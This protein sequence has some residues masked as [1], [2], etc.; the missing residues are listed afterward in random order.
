MRRIH[1]AKRLALGV[2]LAGIWSP[3]VWAQADQPEAEEA[4]VGNDIIVSARRKDESVQDVPMTV[5]VVTDQ[6]LKDLNLFNGSDL[7]NVAPGLTFAPTIPGNT[8]TL[9]LRGAAKGDAAGRQDPTVQTY[10]NEAPVTE[11]LIAEAL[12]DIGQVEVLRGPQGTLRGRPSA[13]GAITV[14]TKRPNLTKV[15][16][17]VSASVSTL[18]QFRGEAALNVPLVQDVLAVRVAGVVDRNENDGVRS[19]FFPDKP[20]Q[21][22]HSWRVSAR[23][24]PSDV[25]DVN[26]MY[27]DFKSTRATLNQVAGNG[28]AG[29]LRPAQGIT[30]GYNGPVISPFDRL[31]LS[32]NPAIRYLNHK[33][34]IGSIVLDLESHKISYVG[35]YNT[36]NNQ[37]YGGGNGVHLLPIPQPQPNPRSLNGKSKL[38]TQELRIESVGNSFWDYGVGLYY[39]KTTSDNLVDAFFPANLGILGNPASMSIGQYNYNY[40]PI[41]RGNFPV[42]WRNQAI[43]FNST[44]HI[45]PKTDLFVGA[46]YVDYKQDSDGYFNVLAGIAATGIPTAFGLCNGTTNLPL[47]PPD[48]PLHFASTL[49]PGQ[50]DKTTPAFVLT[51]SRPQASKENAWVYNASLTHR[52]T[53]DITAYASYGHSWRPRTNNLN[54]VSNDVRITQFGTTRS[55]TSNNYEVG[56]KMAFLDRKL[57]VNVA[58]FLQVYNDFITAAPSVYYL[59]TTTAT[60]KLVNTTLAVNADAKSAGFD[61][62]LAYRPS[63]QF[64]I[65]GNVNYSH[66]R[67]SNANIPCNDSDNNGIPDVGVI[68]TIASFGTDLIKYCNS[69]TAM[70]FQPDWR[71]TMQAEYNLPV[72]DQVDAYVRTLVNYTPSNRFAPFGFTS[73]AYTLVNLFLGVRD[74]EGKWDVGVYSRNLFNTTQIVA[75]G[76]AD[77]PVDTSFAF[78]GIPTSTSSGYRSFGLTQRREFGLTARYSF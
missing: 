43:F 21:R 55:E 23:F 77:V 51:P 64:S 42:N 17:A 67:L 7:V 66:G 50:C 44:F 74:D 26:V 60:T 22:M 9:A 47:D 18:N 63:R 73:K 72:A 28:Y 59:D 36:T 3:Q 65:S 76:I 68:P 25:L 35:Q 30:A 27:Q 34:L 10:L 1:I 39:E 45:T 31:S 56:L 16:G 12:Y 70:S 33:N 62:E 69:N 75:Q 11:V 4:N 71:A 29:P 58:A 37:N 48:L 19:L 49:I 14:T 32:D 53:D 15:E 41:L 6:K 8:P 40:Q 20:Y 13:T 46:R 2:A 54:L 78:L 57:T 5:N 52:F 24:K 61:L 38:I